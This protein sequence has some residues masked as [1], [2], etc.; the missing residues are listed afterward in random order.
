MK[1][2]A[3]C[4]DFSFTSY[5]N[6]EKRFSMKITTEAHGSFPNAASLPK[7]GPRIAFVNSDDKGTYLRAT[8]ISEDVLVL[9]ADDISEESISRLWQSL[10][11]L[12]GCLSYASRRYLWR[13]SKAKGFPSAPLCLADARALLAFV[14]DL[15]RSG[16]QHLTISCEYGKS[17]S[18]TAANFI[19]SLAQDSEPVAP[20]SFPNQW[21]KKCLIQ[22]STTKAQ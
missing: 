8:R 6:I 1:I 13:Q 16:H 15:E 11:R 10:L 7:N 4:L 22:M 3:Q 17:R 9:A 20:L 19:R 18:L 2:Q 12:P 5:D 21:I 14:D